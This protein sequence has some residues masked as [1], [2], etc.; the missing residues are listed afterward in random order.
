MIDTAYVRLRPT[1]QGFQQ[2]A[3]SGIK[4]GLRNV[5][6]IVG[7]AFAAAGVFEAG[8]SIIE[9]AATHQSAFAIVDQT[10]KKA[11][12][13]TDLY[14][15]SVE[16]LLE[17]EARLKGFHDESLASSFVRLVSAT[18]SA[19]QAFKDLGLAEDFSRSS[20]IDV[21]VAALALSRAEQGS[22]QSLS[23]LGVV[24]PKVN[25]AQAELKRR[26]D[27][28]VASGAKFNAQQKLIYA[29]ALAQAA[30]TDKVSN[31]IH[32]LSVVQDRFGGSAAKFAQT[33]SGQFARTG[34]DIHQLEV[35]VGRD[36]LPAINTLAEGIGHYAVQLTH[37]TDVQGAV[38]AGMHDIGVVA[39][40]L[41]D[42][43]ETVGPPLLAVATGAE[44][45][46]AAV[47][48]PAIVASI[49]TFKGLGFATSAAKDAQSLYNRA[50]LAGAAARV[51]ATAETAALTAA[52]SAQ[53][54]AA[55]ASAGG[56]RTLATGLAELASGG[57]GIPI[58]GIAVAALAGG[59]AY[60]A[61]RT[62]T[63][64]R[65]A[66]SLRAT[67]GLL[68]DELN[69][70][71]ELALAVAQSKIDVALA[72]DSKAAADAA[73]QQAA[74]TELGTR[75]TNQHTAAVLALKTARDQDKAAALQVQQAEQSVQ[76]SQTANA[77]NAAA[78]AEHRRQTIE[79]AVATA[80]ATRA[81]DI[82]L[83]SIR[84][85]SGPGPQ[86]NVFASEA[87]R[88]AAAHA[89]QFAAALEKQA[90]SLQKTSPG[91]ATS[92][93]LLGQYAT[94]IGRLPSKAETKFVLDPVNARLNLAQIERD[95]KTTAQA[96]LATAR[97]SGHQI[98][99]SLSDG[100]RTGIDD[101]QA[102]VSAGIAKSVQ[103]TVAA[104]KAAAEA[105][106]PS[107]ATAREIGLPLAQGIVVGINT[108]AP[109]IRRA[110][111]D[112]VGDAIR[113]GGQQVADSINQAK[114]N[115]NQIGSSLSS[116]VGQFIDAGPL[117]AQIKSLQ[118]GL[119][120][121]QNAAQKAQLEQS[122]TAARKALRDEEAAVGPRS[123]QTPSEHRALNA[124]L[125][126]QR[127]QLDQ[128][129]A[130]L[131][132]FNTS[133][134]ITGLQARADK[135]K[136]STT[137]GIA[138]ITDEFNKGAIT[139]QTAN[140]RLAALLAKDHIDYQRAGHVLGTAFADGF[141]ANL[142]GLRNQMVALVGS[143]KLPGAGL[144]P[145]IVRPIQTLQDVTKQIASAQA[146]RDAN[147]LAEQK[148]HTKA[149][150]VI[151][152]A[153]KAAAFTKSITPPGRQ[154]APASTRRK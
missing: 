7:G 43:V 116:T 141:E 56:A 140:R 69:K 14:G 40:D 129:Q 27:E 59:I 121:R 102:K 150:D 142:A 109:D 91:L 33:A 106:S 45:L 86:S 50:L 18:G 148:K 112:T 117:G 17:K 101:S 80:Q 113:Q 126:P 5:G 84:F 61:T 32:A 63:F 95:L 131:A 57:A 19:A 147:A 145:T 108:G 6:S 60:A 71:K 24:I 1:S 110:L 76:T 11:H 99:Q 134:R 83:P 70:T 13:S 132:D 125:A 72:K 94:A 100:V 62:S 103:A 46:A 54:V 51:A 104:G 20:H 68:N 29:D 67:L 85:G 93:R 75:G 3:E 16:S 4:A 8:K 15:V 36:A 35:A 28:A 66:G 10:L 55:T 127:Q 92:V 153:A 138:D 73:V 82:P 9:A 31:R 37:S 115:L 53:L 49:A 143:P 65:A 149:L 114:Q 58:V 90:A 119:T 130:A 26:H 139:S 78:I 120:G 44:Q 151:A 122:V 42:V 123:S 105:K 146:Q 25:V 88:Q 2:E 21:A 81:N 124:F 128:A 39:H 144:A 152:A 118:A 41:K 154:T 64:D 107:A 77:K 48:A 97:R 87:Q 111:T 136:T 98:G 135:L 22:T 34:Q 74:A 47:G 30:A 89:A 96:A 38:K 23:R 79:K 137:Q 52:E 12:Q 133:Q